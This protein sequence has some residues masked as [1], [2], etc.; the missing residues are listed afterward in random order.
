MGLR[1]A[2]TQ[3]MEFEDQPAIVVT[4]FDRRERN[5]V[6]ERIHQEDLCQALALDPSRKYETDGGPGVARMASL[7][8][9]TAG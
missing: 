7:L 4:R 8:R 9:D 2:T 1:V 5:G 6:W 3:Y